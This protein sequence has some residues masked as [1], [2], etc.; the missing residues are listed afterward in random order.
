MNWYLL[1]AIMLAVVDFPFV[2]PV[3]DL[4]TLVKGK[5]QIEAEKRMMEKS[6]QT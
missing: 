3:V 1:F 2:A 5:S 6:K 4:S